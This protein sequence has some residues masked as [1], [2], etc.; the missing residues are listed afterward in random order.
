MDVVGSA[1]VINLQD[2][3]HYMVVLA[4][5][6]VNLRESK[7]FRINNVGVDSVVAFLQ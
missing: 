3:P 7:N 6:F 4:F 5:G 2:L 1:A